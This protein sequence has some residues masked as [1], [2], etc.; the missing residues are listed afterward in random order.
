M[1]AGLGTGLFL[2]DP[3]GCPVNPLD[4]VARAGCD[5][6]P[7]VNFADQVANVAFD[8]DRV[9]EPFG[10]VNSSSAHPRLSGDGVAGPLGNRRLQLLV[11]GDDIRGARILD[12][13]LDAD[14]Q[15]AG[16]AIDLLQ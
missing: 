1:M 8:L 7:A 14:G 11:G 2:T 6:P 10:A 15:P 12:G 5:V 13:W 4:G 16:T 9:V 3:D